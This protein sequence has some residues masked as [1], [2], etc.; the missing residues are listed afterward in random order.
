ME[1]GAK[2]LVAGDLLP[3]GFS[4]FSIDQN[5]LELGLEGLLKCKMLAGSLTTPHTLTFPRAFLSAAQGW[6]LSTFLRGSR[7][8]CWSGDHIEEFTAGYS[9]Y[10]KFS[11]CIWRIRVTLAFH[12][13]AGVETPRPICQVQTFRKWPCYPQ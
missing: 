8:C 11:F 2:L 13:R 10:L 5:H 6:G 12:R 1:G 3:Q 7:F 9:P 4:V